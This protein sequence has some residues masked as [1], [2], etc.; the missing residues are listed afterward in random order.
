[1][2]ILHVI[3][4]SYLF[5]NVR[6]GISAHFYCSSNIEANRISV[7]VAIILLSVHDAY[8]ISNTIC[9][10]NKKSLFINTV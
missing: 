5:S 4:I 7:S 9:Y 6:F 3:L 2:G 10:F 1:M 8:C